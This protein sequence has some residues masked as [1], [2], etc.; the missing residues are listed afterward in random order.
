MK[1]ENFKD[2]HR[3]AIVIVVYFLYSSPYD[4]YIVVEKDMWE[5]RNNHCHDKV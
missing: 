3:S 2:K 4:E 1:F 5:I